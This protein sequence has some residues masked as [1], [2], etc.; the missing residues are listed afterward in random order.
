M[1]KSARLRLRDLRA[2]HTLV[3]ECRELGDDA[4]LWRGH[5]LT[6]LT[7]DTGAMVAAEY[8]GVFEPTFEVDGVSDVGWEGGDR[9]Y[10]AAMNDEF[11][12]RG[13]GFNPM[14]PAYMAASVAGCGPCLTRSDI[15]TDTE[16]YGSPYFQ[17]YHR[18][19]GADAIMY[20][21]L[22]LPVGRMAGLTLTR[23]AGAADFAPRNRAYLAEVL[24][25]IA[26]LVGGPVARFTEPAPSALPPRVRQV[27]R[28]LLEGD[29]DKQIAARLG[30]S[31]HT[32]NEYVKRVFRHFGVYSRPELLARW[33]RRGWGAKFAWDPGG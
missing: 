33:I 23:A 13:V 4:D 2:I 25:R 11:A 12:R 21:I 16:W 30:L 5:L 15:L 3:G 8:E 24:G 1:S 17:H 7:L 6:R 14:Y 32:V 28:C 22:P 29:S 19:S 27:L 20:C 10:F 18:P 31:Q 26:P 9:R